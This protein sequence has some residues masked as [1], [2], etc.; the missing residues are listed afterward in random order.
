MQL[1]D[2]FVSLAKDS[3]KP[4]LILCD[5]GAMDGSAYIEDDLW[6]EIKAEHDLD[7]VTLR[8]TRY[9]A[10][11]HLI[12]AAKGAEEFYSLANNEIRIEDPSTACKVDDLLCNAWV[13]HPKLHVFGK[14]T[15][16]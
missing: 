10:V 15:I 14:Y 6:E 2:S 9:N 1:E 12:T 3:G 4:S 13:G 5:R 8:D 11:F 7:T 16:H